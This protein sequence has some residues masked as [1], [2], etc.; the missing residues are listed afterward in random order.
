M[1]ITG[2]NR[3]YRASSF[4][5]IEMSESAGCPDSHPR[6]VCILGASIFINR[7]R[8]SDRLFCEAG[9]LKD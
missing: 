6:S 8:I 9:I 3:R 5:T 4:Q 7:P 2:V 1:N